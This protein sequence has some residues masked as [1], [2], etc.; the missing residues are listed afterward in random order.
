MPWQKAN[1]A[2]IELLDKLMRNYNC[3]RRPIF[4]SPTFF[5]LG[6]MFTGV[7]ADTVFLRL[8]PAD[9]KQIQ[10]QLK[11][12]KPFN[13]MGKIIMKEYIAL[14]ESV[15]NQS[16]VLKDWLNKSYAFAASLPLKAAKRK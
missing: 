8:S 13:P 15:A 7:Q 11:E 6:N 9:L 16:E 2:L 14:P 1:K 12:A 5:V 10:A 3:Y 4:G